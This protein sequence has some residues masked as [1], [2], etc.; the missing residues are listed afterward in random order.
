MLGSNDKT[1]LAIVE[2]RQTALSLSESKASR[3][4]LTGSIYLRSRPVRNK[5]LRGKFGREYTL[6]IS[7][8]TE[9]LMPP[10][11]WP[12][13]TVLVLFSLL[14]YAAPVIQTNP[15]RRCRNAIR[16]PDF[17]LPK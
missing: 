1:P 2:P 9:V 5:Q 17:L 6:N 12:H 10:Q 8:L 4:G 7:W 11:I 16:E 15:S 13:L 14:R 3:Q